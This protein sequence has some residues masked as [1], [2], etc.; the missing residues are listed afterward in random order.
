MYYIESRRAI[1]PSDSQEPA[2]FTCNF[3]GWVVLQIGF[4]WSERSGFIVS[5]P[6]QT[7]SWLAWLACAARISL[8]LSPYTSH[9]TA[10]TLL[11]SPY[12][13]HP[14]PLT[15]LPSPYSSHPTPLTLLC[16]LR[17]LAYSKLTS[18]SIHMKP[19]L[20]RYE[21]EYNVNIIW[22]QLICGWNLIF[23]LFCFWFYNCIASFP[24]KS[25]DARTIKSCSSSL[26]G[27][28]KG[29]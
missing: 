2:L 24:S 11:L 28:T 26:M 22:I 18:S 1:P 5:I 6:A 15:L 8:L 19:D 14:T 25:S 12:C 9:P 3:L 10:L 20:P 21:A 23:L 13:S 27:E 4:K 17:T 7:C 16:P 29:R